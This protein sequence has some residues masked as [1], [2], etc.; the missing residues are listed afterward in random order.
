MGVFV[1]CLVC[2]S[3]SDITAK[4][5]HFIGKQ[6]RGGV[7]SDVPCLR[8]YQ[9]GGVSI[10]GDYLTYFSCGLKVDSWMRR[11]RADSH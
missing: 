6:Q 8:V 1:S 5:P 11:R 3:G 9:S 10:T 2:F 7:G 4:R